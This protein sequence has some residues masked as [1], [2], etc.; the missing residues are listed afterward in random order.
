MTGRLR[1]WVASGVILILASP[2][3]A[4]Q[5]L[6]FPFQAEVAGRRVYSERPISARLPPLLVAANAKVK[7]SP[8]AAARRPDQPIFLTDGGWRWTWLAV[9]SRGAFAL[10]R[11]FATGIVVNRSDAERDQ[12]SNGRGVGGRR[13]LSGVI[14]HEMTHD[15]LRA[16]FGLLV[17]LKTPTWLREGYCDHVAGD[18]SLS[19]AQAQQLITAGED[20]PALPYWRGRKRVAAELAANGGSVDAL[21]ARWGA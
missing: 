2:L 8:I 12:V 3:A 4:P 20:H 14:A 16:R 6:A 11:P 7:A 19:D 5:L 9:Q 17:D 1:N 15:M 13:S 21:F 18:G 10:T